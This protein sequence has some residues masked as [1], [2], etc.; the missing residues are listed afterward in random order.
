HRHRRGHAPAVGNRNKGKRSREDRD[1]RQSLA[2]WS[3]AAEFGDETIDRPTTLSGRR[4]RAT[5]P[6]ERVPLQS[7]HP[8]RRSRSDT[9]G[10]PTITPL[11]AERDGEPDTDRLYADGGRDGASSRDD[12]RFRDGAPGSRRSRRA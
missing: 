1:Q 6:D 3:S 8:T 2:N 5:R 7:E 12:G 4:G 11:Y 9:A 10:W